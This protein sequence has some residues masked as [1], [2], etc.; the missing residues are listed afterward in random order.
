MQTHSRLTTLAA[1]RAQST[2]PPR[3]GGVAVRFG[4]VVTVLALVVALVGLVSSTPA[5]AAAGKGG[6]YAGVKVAGTKGAW[7]GSYRVA[8]A[9]VYRVDPA[10][11]ATKTSYGSPQ[12]VLSSSRRSQRAGYVLATYGGRKDRVQAAAVDATITHLLRGGKWKIKKQLGA[13]RIRRSGAKSSTVRKYARTMLKTSKRYA[14]P[15][16]TSLAA[17]ASGIGFATKLTFTITTERGVGLPN[18]PVT[19]RYGYGAPLSAVTDANG[20][21]TVSKTVDSAGHYTPSATASVPEW[22]LELRI[23]TKRKRARVAT[24]GLLTTLGASTTVSWTGG[25]QIKINTNGTTGQRGQALTPGSSYTVVG[26]VGTQ[27]VRHTLYGPMNDP[28]AGCVGVAAYDTTTSIT[29]SGTFPL[30]SPAAAYTGYYRW[31]VV[32]NGND[33]TVSASSC[34]E[35]I[36]VVAPLAVSTRANAS[37]KKIF[38]EVIGFDRVEA[39]AVTVYR[40][41]SSGCS[42]TPTVS[43]YAINGNDARQIADHSAGGFGSSYV[44]AVS[45][46]QFLGAAVS[47]CRFYP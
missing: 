6:R 41:I 37:G 44:V 5:T 42:G 22:R 28:A 2:T 33:N 46:G 26:A 13:G 4:A 12:L 25:Q 18:V 38:A 23:P 11:R 39:H 21:A 8:G 47:P 14:G 24:A 43:S 10:K 30:P 31:G 36:G 40:Y 3:A 27:S 15:Y 20:V 45:G 17:E 35:P 32:G 34:G 7:M 1:E 19:I 29:G 9:T 16:K